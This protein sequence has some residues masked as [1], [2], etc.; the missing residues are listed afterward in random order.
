MKRRK[1]KIRRRMD[2]VQGNAEATLKLLGAQ[3]EVAIKA[4]DTLQRT[5]NEA[6]AEKL[7]LETEFR[8]LRELVDVQQKL[9]QSELAKSAVE[10]QLLKSGY[11]PAV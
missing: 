11:S 7:R 1:V 9:H 6:R 4:C 2:Q 8:Y 3:I 10:K 5:T